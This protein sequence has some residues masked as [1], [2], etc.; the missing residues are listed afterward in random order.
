[1]PPYLS[2]VV[3]GR[4]DNYGGDFNFRLQNLTIWLNSMVEKEQLPTE[5]II[6]NY[7]PLA[8]KPS[9]YEAI[10]WPK[11]RHYL[12]IRIINV[13]NEIHEQYFND[14]NIRKPVP[15]FEYVGKNI[16]IRRAKGEFILASNPDI[17][18]HPKI[19]KFIKKGWIKRGQFYRTDRCDYKKGNIGALE[20]HPDELQKIIDNVF[21][22]FLKGNIY[23]YKK[24]GNFY[25][26]LQLYRLYNDMWLQRELWKTEFTGISKY[27]DL[28]LNPDNVEFFCHC[29]ASGDFLMAHKSYWAA[30]HSYPE[31]TYLS[32]HTDSLMV[33]MLKALGLKEIVF[34]VPI[35]HC[36]HERRYDAAKET[37]NQVMRKLYTE[38]Q[39]NGKKMLRERKPIIY[40]E[41]NWGAK[42]MIFEEDLV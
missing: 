32:L 18:Y 15:V 40:N 25:T 9:M 29:N 26:T 24:I 31:S 7:N 13:P 17:I 41:A 6:V 11:N 33:I 3:V 2:I 27:F 23:E 34:T 12:T 16:G 22:L 20:G 8:D 21:R 38:M 10:Q 1:M 19:F 14:P 36:D 42:G 35:F 28:H 39:T 37:Q 30:L 4:N 5:L